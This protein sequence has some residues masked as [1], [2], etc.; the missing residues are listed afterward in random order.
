MF[1][2][3]N[4]VEEFST[5]SPRR[6]IPPVRTKMIEFP[7]RVHIVAFYGAKKVT[8]QQQGNMTRTVTRLFHQTPIN[9]FDIKHY[10]H[11]LTYRPMVPDMTKQ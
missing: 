1:E 7:Q 8:C 11:F 6:I 3:K 4:L 10:V 9:Q 5:F 2:S